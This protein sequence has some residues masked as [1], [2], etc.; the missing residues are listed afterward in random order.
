MAELA[1][2]HG[3]L[4]AVVSIV[5]DQAAEKSRDIGTKAFHAAI[6][7]QSAD[8][9]NAQRGAAGFESMHSLRRSHGRAIEVDRN[10]IG[11]GGLDHVAREE[12]SPC[13]PW[14]LCEPNY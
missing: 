6:A 13:P 9:D 5:R 10:L 12:L 8:H 4:A 3:D 7:L 11:L 14:G 2:E 1:G